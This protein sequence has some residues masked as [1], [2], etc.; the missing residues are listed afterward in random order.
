M[1]DLSTLL[2]ESD[3]AYK[4]TTSSDDYVVLRKVCLYKGGKL[5]TF[6]D[7]QKDPY[8]KKTWYLDHK[9]ELSGIALTNKRVRPS[10]T[11]AITASVRKSRGQAISL[12]S[13]CACMHA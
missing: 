2:K 5:V 8:N 12:V 10:G 11:W 4:T 7:V 6:H 9:C 13:L 3:C 1:L